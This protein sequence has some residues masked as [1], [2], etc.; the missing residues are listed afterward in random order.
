MTAAVNR[1]PAIDHSGSNVGRR[2]TNRL[3]I[4][5]L[6]LTSVASLLAWVSGLGPFHVWFGLVTLPGAV[7]LILAGRWAGSPKGLATDPELATAIRLGVVA[8][9][10]GTLGY[11]LFRV[12]FIVFGG[13]RL[14]APIESYGV[15]ALGADTSSA[16]TD[17]AGW[18]YHVSN[19]VG[20]GVA[21]AVV[22]TRRHWAWGV[23]W[24]MVLESA[25]V[26]SPFAQAYSLSGKWGIIAIAYAAHVPFGLALGVI[27]QRADRWD[28]HLLEISPRSV[29]WALALTG[30]GLFLWHSPLTEDPKVAAGR[31][32]AEG[33]SAQISEGGLSPE[34][35]HVGV[36]GCAA[37][38][39]GDSLRH[40]LRVG[41]L[42][43]EVA[44]GATE[45][46]CFDDPGVHRIRTTGEPFD[47]GFVI[48]DEGFRR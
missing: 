39:N 3:G 2:W 38:H 43:T 42:E 9:L 22:A 26:L 6:G 18:A 27:V 23:L 14:F 19:G 32:V 13:L 40:L 41:D 29:W 30:S 34:W 24:A 17:L 15:L 4:A 11:D 20:F 1:T 12:P 37:L 25:T 5:A 35:L 33:P 47:G 8:G 48:V 28:R 31:A 21:Y 44:A 36:G 46:L 16:W 10:I 7:A 45:L